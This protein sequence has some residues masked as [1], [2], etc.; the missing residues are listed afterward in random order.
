MPAILLALALGVIFWQLTSLNRQVEGIFCNSNLMRVHYF[1]FFAATSC[2]VAILVI[3]ILFGA[4]Y[5]HQDGQT[6]H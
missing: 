6:N 4:E 1:A 3:E 5:E 2:S